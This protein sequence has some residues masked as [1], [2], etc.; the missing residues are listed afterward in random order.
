VE[1]Q[2]LARPPRGKSGATRSLISCAALLVKVI[3]AMWSGA[4]AH[5]VTR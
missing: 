4:T 1:I 5:C 2:G 3:A